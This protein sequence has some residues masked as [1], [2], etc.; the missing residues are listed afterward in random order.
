MSQLTIATP[1]VPEKKTFEV[2]YS[3]PATYIY[4]LLLLLLNM[5]YTDI[6]NLAI[7][8]PQV[9]LNGLTNYFIA[10]MTNSRC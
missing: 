5:L 3:Q 2:K 9:S 4:P 1:H 7:T 10:P 8:A 6:L